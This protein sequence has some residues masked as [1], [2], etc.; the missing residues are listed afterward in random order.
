MPINVGGN[1]FEVYILK[2]HVEEAL[3]IG[4]GPRAHI[5]QVRWRPLIMSFCRF[6]GLT[7]R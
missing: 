6:L 2:L 1:E 7:K 3:L 5:D 4:D